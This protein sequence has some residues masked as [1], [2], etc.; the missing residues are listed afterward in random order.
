MEGSLYVATIVFVSNIQLECLPSWAWQLSAPCIFLSW[1]NFM[2]FIESSQYSRDIRCHVPKYDKILS[3]DWL[4]WPF[5]LFWPLDNCFYATPF[6]GNTSE[7]YW[8][9]WWILSFLKFQLAK[10]DTTGE[11]CYIPIPTAEDPINDN[12]SVGDWWN[13]NQ[14]YTCPP[15]RRPLCRLSRHYSLVFSL[16]GVVQKNI[17]PL[18]VISPT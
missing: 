3:W 6:G 4:Q 9:Q 15:F 1:I 5:S 8:K 2:L 12:R 18:P 17:L 13:Q 16:A 10:I 11:V 7:C 14:T